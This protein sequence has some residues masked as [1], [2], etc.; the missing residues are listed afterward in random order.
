MEKPVLWS[1]KK[2]LVAYYSFSGNTRFVA[3]E[4]Q[5]QTYGE[6]WEIRPQKSYPMQYNACVE[7]ARKEIQ[8]GFQPELAVSLKNLS[9]YDVIFVGS[10][11]WWSTIAPPVAT[12]LSQGDFS[13]KIII[14]FITHGGG[15][16]ARCAEAIRKRS[17]S[18]QHLS[19]KAFRGENIRRES[20]TIRQW[21]ASVGRNG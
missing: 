5:K 21:L 3:E 9:D 19:G 17:P 13:G 14:P 20:D 8:A 2:I 12:F 4:I 6:I 1:G 15:G 11:N 7:Q 10:P 16:M 18:S